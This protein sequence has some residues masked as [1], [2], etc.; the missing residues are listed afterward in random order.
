MSSIC[1]A[2]AQAALAKLPPLSMAAVTLRLA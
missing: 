1:H 2:E